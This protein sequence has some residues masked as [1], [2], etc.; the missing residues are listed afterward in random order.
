MDAGQLPLSIEGMTPDA[1]DGIKRI[2][3]ENPRFVYSKDANL[4]NL[5]A[6]WAFSNRAARPSQER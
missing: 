5:V 2:L 3:E 6:E 1:L 4:P